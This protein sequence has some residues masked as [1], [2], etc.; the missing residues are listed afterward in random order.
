MD[1]F[2]LVAIVIFGILIL[3]LTGQAADFLKLKSKDRRMETLSESRLNNR[4]VNAFDNVEYRIL[5][6]L[7]QGGGFFDWDGETVTGLNRTQKTFTDCHPSQFK[8]SLLEGLRTGKHIYRYF[9]KDVIDVSKDISTPVAISPEYS[10][11]EVERLRKEDVLQ[12]TK[13]EG[14][15]AKLRANTEESVNSIIEHSKDIQVSKFNPNR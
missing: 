14:E 9:P 13:L 4:V 3:A 10:N 5:S 1:L 8:E 11:E 12:R 15:I 2:Q 7:E 6:I